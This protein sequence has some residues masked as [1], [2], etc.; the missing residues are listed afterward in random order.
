MTKH[1]VT[2]VI[3]KHV[4]VQP[5][6]DAY[7]LQCHRHGVIWRCI[8]PILLESPPRLAKQLVQS[9]FLLSQSK[10]KRIKPFKDTDVNN[11]NNTNN[12]EQNTQK[13]GNYNDP[14][15]VGAGF[16]RRQLLVSFSSSDL[17][18]PPR[19][20]F[21]LCVLPPTTTSPDK[22]FLSVVLKTEHSMLQLQSLSAWLSTLGGGYFFCKRLSVSLQ[23]ARR[24]KALA[25]RLND[26][27]MVRQCSINE[28]YNLIYAGKFALARAVLN[29]LEATLNDKD[30]TS[31]TWRQCQAARLF[32]KRLKH[33]AKKGVLD[34]YH[35]TNKKENHTIDDYQRIRIVEEGY[36]DTTTS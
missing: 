11:T 14:Y 3:P 1:K 33:V 8:F 21:V 5:H 15:T 36:Y 31:V 26:I 16:F 12:N 30:G 24:Q 13:D 7:L 19:P 20:N 32:A 28:A 35:P 18:I 27:S 2:I 17:M 9:M 10:T 22:T 25:V 29:E 6:H 23:L 34:R 4:S